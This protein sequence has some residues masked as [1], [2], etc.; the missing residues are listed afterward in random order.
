MDPA[1]RV[2]PFCGEPPGAGV[3]CAVCGRNLTDI[4]RLPT[5][6][7]W[8]RGSAETLDA[9]ESPAPASPADTVA[10]FLAAMHA[11]GDPGAT[12]M[13]RAEPGFLGRARHAHGWVVR[14]VDRGEDDSPSRHEPGLFVT[15]DGHLHRLDS[16][17]RGVG[18]RT[19]VR[20]VDIVG[21]EVT[22]PAYGERLAGEL[23]AVLRANG[24]DPTT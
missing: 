11:A 7:A 6:G 8:E 23:A 21:P 1:A 17:S 10:A 18:Q 14:A 22:E 13:V 3:F 5:R 24:L 15:V 19:A 4:Q 16:A 9:A 20:Y 2:C 12:N